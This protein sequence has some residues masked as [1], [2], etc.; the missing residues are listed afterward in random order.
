MISIAIA[1]VIMISIAKPFISLALLNTRE[2][3]EWL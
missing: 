3:Q 2:S 1:M